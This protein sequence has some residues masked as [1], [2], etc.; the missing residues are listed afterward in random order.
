M[1]REYL[2]LTGALRVFNDFSHTY[3]SDFYIEHDIRNESLN[4]LRDRYKID[5]VAGNDEDF[6]K[7][8]RLMR[9]VYDNVLHYGVTKSLEF[10]PKDSISILDYSFGKG[11]EYGVYCRLQAIVF[12][13]CCLSIGLK[14]RTI[15]CLPFSPNDFDSHVVSMVCI[16]SMG[17]WVLFDPS[18]NAYFTDNAG[19]AL[20][21]LEARKQLS[22]DQINVNDDLQP[23]GT[24]EFTEKAN[25]YKQYMAKNLFY[26]KCSAYNTFGTDLIK[27][28]RIYHLIPNGFNVKEREI[29]CCEYAIRNSPEA[30]RTDWVNDLENLKKQE[31][32][33]ISQ[34][35]FLRTE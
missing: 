33:V 3:L 7:A 12:T 20:S 18:N 17:K 10:L 5:I 34:E 23:R 6:T 28:Q 1:N 30:V 35:Q 4:K 13:E 31:I 29:A 14:A 15:H 26:I 21:P 11:I 24:H 16:N 22:L 19:I 25:L 27:T 8:Y 32:N 9:W 2:L